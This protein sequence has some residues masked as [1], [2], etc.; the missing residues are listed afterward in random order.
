MF[1]E[2]GFCVRRILVNFLRHLVF[3]V[4]RNVLFSLSIEACRDGFQVIAVACYLC[5]NVVRTRME[6]LLF[7]RGFC[8]MSQRQ[9]NHIETETFCRLRTFGNA[10]LMSLNIIERIWE[11]TFV[12]LLKKLF[13]S[14]LLI[15]SKT[16]F[17]LLKSAIAGRAL[18]RKPI[19]LIKFR[20]LK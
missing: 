10:H 8:K 3:S 7:P 15:S 11:L 1:S 16:V 14:L 5:R 6:L 4:H 13:H 18:K 19:E 20:S 2:K 9:S 17:S 12:Y